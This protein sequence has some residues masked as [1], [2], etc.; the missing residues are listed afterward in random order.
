MNE[1]GHSLTFCI[2]FDT[3]KTWFE[4]FCQIT[5]DLWSFFGVNNGILI[6]TLGL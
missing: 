5:T 1:S 4:I 3:E 6:N 2:I